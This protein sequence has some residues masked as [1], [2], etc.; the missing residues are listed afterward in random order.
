M[1][2]RA[3]NCNAVFWLPA[4]KWQSWPRLAFCCRRMLKNNGALPLMH[5]QVYWHLVNVVFTRF[6]VPARLVPAVDG[7]AAELAWRSEM[8]TSRF[9]LRGFAIQSGLTGMAKR[10]FAGTPPPDLKWLQQIESAAY[11]VFLN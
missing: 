7:I 6:F 2:Q 3:G 1:K 11:G 4:L 9:V 10:G 5:W 8:L